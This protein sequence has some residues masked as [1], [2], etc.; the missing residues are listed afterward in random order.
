[1]AAGVRLEPALLEKIDA[2]LEPVVQ[3]DPTLTQSPASRP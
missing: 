3:R 2:V 1:V